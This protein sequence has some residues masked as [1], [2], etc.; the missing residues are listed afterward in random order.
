MGKIVDKNGKPIKTIPK[1]HLPGVLVH[2][3]GAIHCLLE[4]HQM[5][6]VVLDQCQK[7]SSDELIDIIKETMDDK[8]EIDVVELEVQLRGLLKVYAHITSLIGLYAD[9]TVREEDESTKLF[10]P[11]N[12]MVH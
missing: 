1:K 10:V 12:G 8:V 2:L 4:N 7:L 6:Q 3:T 9:K 11:D 5:F